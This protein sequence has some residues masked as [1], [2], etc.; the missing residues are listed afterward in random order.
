MIR[1]HV[2]FAGLLALAAGA[3]AAQVEVITQSDLKKRVERLERM[4]ENPVLLQLSDRLAEQ[5]K[6]IQSMQDRIDRL[7][8]RLRQQD[9]RHKGQ[10]E[11]LQARIADLE[12]RLKQEKT[13]VTAEEGN[14][15]AASTASTT[16]TDRAD[17]AQMKA[18]DAAMTLLRKAQYD[19]AAAA[20]DAFLKRYPDAALAPNAAYWAAEAYMVQLKFKAALE[21]FDRVLKAFPD[22][23]KY[24]D[25]LYRSAEALY[26]LG[27]KQDAQTRLKRLLSDA[28]APD[29]L[30]KRAQA[31][32]EKWRGAKK[33]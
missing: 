4:L 27:R 20:F 26:K 13:V 8:F 32:L 17:Q 14:K 9:S 29:E 12:A 6:E 16:A 18:Y 22:S 25:S 15:P 28:K 7:E 10:I 3:Q 19:K 30:K 21:R 5:Q 11:A 24:Y 33:G 1:K 23:G 31:Q 2:L